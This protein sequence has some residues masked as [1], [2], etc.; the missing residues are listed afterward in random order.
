MHCPKCE[1]SR[2]LYVRIYTGWD[3]YKVTGIKDAII[4]IDGDVADVEIGEVLSATVECQDC[5]HV[6]VDS[7]D[8]DLYG[9]NWI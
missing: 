3:S 4:D 1:G 5:N 2:F 7:K 8:I 9:E 6:I